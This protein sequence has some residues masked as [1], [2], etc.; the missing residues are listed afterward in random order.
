MSDFISPHPRL[1]AILAADVVGYSRLMEVDEVGTLNALKSRRREIVEPLVA[2][3]QGRIFKVTGDAV[4]IEFSSPVNAV[5]CAIELQAGMACA[6]K[7]V[8][9][10]RHVNLRV[11]INLG[12]VLIEGR[13]LYGDSVNV[14]ARLESIAAPGGIMISGSTYDHIANKVGIGFEDLGVRQLKNIARP[15]RV[16]RATGT[17]SV[18]NTPGISLRA[19]TADLLATE[20]PTVAVLPFVNM[21]GNPDPDF[22]CDGMTEN[23]ITGLSRFRDLFVIASNSTFAYKGCAVNVQEVSRDLGAR[24]ILEG[25][26]QRHTETLRVNVRLIDGLTGRHLWAERYDRHID[27]IF[28]VQDEVT[29]LIVGTLASTHGGRLNK[30]WRHGEAAALRNGAANGHAHPAARDDEKG[31]GGTKNLPALSY[32]L[33]GMELLHSFNKEN[34]QRARELFEISAQLDP[35][36]AKPVSKIAW[37]HMVDANFGWVEDAAAALEKGLEFASAAIAIDDDEAWGH[38]ALAGYY[39]FKRRYGPAVAEYEKAVARNPNDADTLTDYAWCLDYAGRPKAALE[40]AHKAM[41]L[42]PYCPEWY[43]AQL[44]QIYFDARQYEDAV[45]SLSGLRD[46]DTVPIHLILAASHAALDNDAAR[47]AIAH[48]LE[49]DLA[50]FRNKLRKAGLGVARH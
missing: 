41:R 16:Y 42:N 24:Y 26:V 31:G 1:V 3:H 21:S 12:D 4:L 7:A 10:D 5:K 13:D 8:A 23:I 49:L 50:H 35:S 43:V 36:Y 37:C 9:E 44:G 29:A 34:N 22:F 40:L 32:F 17:P 2:R 30:A 19:S 25:S 39:M 6:N 27:C 20:K 11:G 47:Q 14:A 18:M 38:H 48:V 46:L 28:A 33:R 45:T 15:V